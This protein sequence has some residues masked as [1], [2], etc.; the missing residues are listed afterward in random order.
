M[1]VHRINYGSELLGHHQFR[2]GNIGFRKRQAVFGIDPLILV[3]T[4]ASG[5]VGESQHMGP[6]LK[7]FRLTFHHQPN[8]FMSWITMGT[9]KFM[10][11]QSPHHHP[12]KITSAD[13][14]H[15][16]LNSYISW[17]QRPHLNF[18]AVHTADF[19]QPGSSHFTHDSLKI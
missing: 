18:F 8:P 15:L 7:L 4:L 6:L 19:H 16:R 13:R 2:S 1:L 3:E 5:G 9:G 14:S 17:L 10:I 12:V 11:H